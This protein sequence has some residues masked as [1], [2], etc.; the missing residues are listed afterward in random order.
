MNLLINEPPLQVLPTLAERIGLNEALFLQQLHYWLQRSNNW[1]DGRR[2]C[3]KSA[4]DWTKEF[5]F[6][7]SRTIKRITTSLKK[8]NLIIT[9]Q[10][11]KAGF[12]RTTWYT[13]NYEQLEQ[14]S[15]SIVTDCPNPKGQVGTTIVTDCPNAKGHFVPTNTIEYTE[16][17]T[18]NTQKNNTVSGADQ[19][20]LSERFESLWKLYPRKSRKKDAFNAYKRA[21]KKGVSDEEIKAGIEKYKAQIKAQHTSTQYIAQGGTWFNQERWA[22]EYDIQPH[23]MSSYMYTDESDRL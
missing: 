23:G 2:W 22:D 7:S 10:F 5:P 18:E 1:R 6:W 13:V 9:G 21:V 16:T 12:D 15:Q 4:E 19:E 20:T 14:A 11:N 3:Y 8:Q 17:T